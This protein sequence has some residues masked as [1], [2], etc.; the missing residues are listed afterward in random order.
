MNNS[1]DFVSVYNKF[2]NKDHFSN[3][4]RAEIRRA[5]EPSD[6]ETLPAFYK[7]LGNKLNKNNEKQWQRVVFF[8]V[9][10]LKHSESGKEQSGKNVQEK[11]NI[12]R[13]KVEHFKKQTPQKYLSMGAALRQFGIKEAR[14]FQVKRSESPNDLIQLRRLVIQAKPKVD[15]RKFAERLWYWGENSKKQILKDYFIAETSED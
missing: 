6:L 7:L 8:L 5:I 3:G 15:F 12:N 11:N 4:D 14:I 2:H 9:K 13:N 1:P 10:N